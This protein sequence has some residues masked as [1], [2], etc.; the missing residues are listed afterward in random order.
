LDFGVAKMRKSPTDLEASKS[1]TQT[2]GLI[3][4]PL[5]MSPEQAIG[6]KSFDA[7]TDVFSLGVVLYE[8]LTGRV[9]HE[10]YDTLGR[11]IIAICQEPAAHVQDVAPWVPG[12]IAQIVHTALEIDPGDRFPTAL[13][14]LDAIGEVL[15]DGWEIEEGALAPMSDEA[16]QPAPRI[17]LPRA[18][19]GTAAPHTTE[20][21]VILTR[22]ENG[23][24]TTVPRVGRASVSPRIIALV[25]AVALAAGGYA[26]LRPARNTPTMPVPTAAAKPAAEP[27]P[28]VTAIAPADPPPSPTQAQAAPDPRPPVRPVGA[29]GHAPPKATTEAHPKGAASAPAPPIPTTRK[30]GTSDSFE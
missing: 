17:A 27:P 6:A 30:L 13:A 25:S 20:G 23:N 16:K 15:E 4:S 26:L 19:V 29:V 11:L 9:P 14:M 3:G 8:M 22:T 12:P 21:D 7:R 2:G 28:P 18:R 24:A 1:L 5:Y 10:A